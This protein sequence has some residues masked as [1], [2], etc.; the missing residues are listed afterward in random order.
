MNKLA[1]CILILVLVQTHLY[2]QNKQIDQLIY[3]KQFTKADSLLKVINLSRSEKMIYQALL[4]NAFYQPESSNNLIK[5]VLSGQIAKYGKAVQYHLYRALYDNYAQLCNYRKA[6]QSSLILSTKFRS[7]MDSG[8]V[9]GLQEETKIYHALQDVKPQSL[10]KSSTSFIRIT[11]DLAG[12]INI[13]LQTGGASGSFIF[14][15]GANI[16]TITE[17]YAQK[18]NLT[19]LPRA[20]VN[21]AGSFN[22]ISTLAQL[23]I[24][25]VLK[26]G[27]VS[28]RNVVFL[29]FP[30]ST[31]TFAGG[32]YKINGIIGF[33]VIRALEEI[34][35]TKD[36]LT[37][38]ATPETA[39]GRHNLA[40]DGLTPL[41]YLNYS[42]TC[43]PF[44]FDSGAQ[45]SLFNINFYNRFK[46]RIDKDAKSDSL[47][48]GGAGGSKD[49]KTITAAK[50][51][52]NLGSS[53][54][55][56]PSAQISLDT[57]TGND[58]FYYGNIGLDLVSQFSEVTFNFPR[59]TITLRK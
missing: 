7:F 14:D 30:D 53:I 9:E 16:S 12:L 28:V 2:G 56:F 23:G 31:L 57:I 27:Q 41:I 13:P 58:K 35:L 49:I 59:A 10:F 8:D 50:V 1:F 26:I 32:A 51:C 34:I 39:Q 48:L 54:Y 43:L 3:T 36:T 33:P 47:R 55:C 22:G 45:S 15:T 5:K 4:M 25:K 18:L 19:I 11:H 20:T 24:A 38:P 21:V 46:D 44:T 6:Y 40:S 37:I 29:V 17:T 42:G 52:L